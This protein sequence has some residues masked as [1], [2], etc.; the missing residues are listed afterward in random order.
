MASLEA[1]VRDLQYKV[2]G[3]SPKQEEHPSQGLVMD[4]LSG[5]GNAARLHGDGVRQMTGSTVDLTYIENQNTGEKIGGFVASAGI[6]LG[7]TL[8]AKKIP[9]FGQLAE[10]KVASMT[11]GGLVGLTMP[12]Q[13]G[14]GAM[15]RLYN[16]A[17]GAGTVGLME[18]GPGMIGK[19]PGIRGLGEKS[20]AGGLTRAAGAN[21]LAG[22]VNTEATSYI[23]TGHGASAGELAMGTGTWMA[24][25]TAFHAVGMKA[26]RIAQDKAAVQSWKE[27]KPWQFKEVQNINA[28][29]LRAGQQLAPGHYN[30][31]FESQGAARAFNL[32]VSEGAVAGKDAPV[33]TFL[34]G[35]TPKGTS[36]KIIRELE[37]NR[38]A[39]RD[40]AVVAY[41]HARDGR[42]GPLTGNSQSWNDTNFG[43]TK[44]DFTYSDQAAFKDMMSVISQHVPT[45]NTNSIAL[46]GFSLGG[47]MANRIAATTPEVST[48]ATIHGT[49]D[50]LDEQI[51]RASMHRHPIDVQVVHGTADRVLPLNGGR[52]FFTALL[53]NAGLS[54][55]RRQAPFWAES[56]LQLTSSPAVLAENGG[57]P[58][59]LSTESPNFSQRVTRA[60]E[61]RV[62][63]IIERNGPHA[64]NGA[65]AQH[66][67]IQTLMGK[68][69]PASYFDVRQR[70]WDFMIDS[71]RR[72]ISTPQNTRVSTTA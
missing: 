59:F 64:I 43:Y 30:I 38:F 71:V 2:Y 51:M 15:T 8:L 60:G 61:H 19:L 21:G 11:A 55:P 72:H 1:Q 68:P 48:L 35:L 13:E 56:N 24:M 32:Y 46:S 10:G 39:D 42:H 9:F 37:Y 49:M 20:W 4:F 17:L 66:N 65:P 28:A 34:H 41:L 45:A 3:D 63:E 5:A 69:L 52:S 62:T 70:S 33:V 57:K 31:T 14:Q 18:Y 44:A 12:L 40:G 6:F 27:N 23:N 47:K 29:D 7:T 16:T 67:I 25:G 58:S 22:F 53:E 50:K 54:T 26:E 36:H